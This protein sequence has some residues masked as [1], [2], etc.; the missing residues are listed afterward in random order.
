MGASSAHGAFPGANGQ[1]A[2]TRCEDGY[3]CA[4]ARIWT[5]NGDGS[6]A[7][8]LVDDPGHWD[9]DPSFSSDGR[10]IVFQRCVINGACGIAAVDV[11]GNGLHQLTTGGL[12]PGDD[13]PAFSPDG[14]KIVFE[15]WSPGPEIFQIWVMGAD[16]S[17]PHALTSGPAGNYAPVFSPDGKQ[18]VYG[19]YTNKSSQVWLMNADGSNPHQLTSPVGMFDSYPRFSPDGTHIAFTR[20]HGGQCPVWIMA[21]DGSG[22]HQVT[23]SSATDGRPDFSPDGTRLVFQRNMPDGTTS[24][25]TQAVSGGS[26]TRLTTTDDYSVSWGRVPT[27]SIDSA[28]TIAGAARAGHT[29]TATAGATS[30]GGSTS[31]QWL[32]CAASCSPIAGAT[33]GSYKATNAD[34]GAQLEVQQTQASA[35]GSVTALSAASAQVAAEPGAAIVKLVRRS[36]GRVLVRLLC[37]AEQSGVCQ[38]RVSLAVAGTGKHRVAFASGSFQLAAG[39]SGKV[40]LR[41]SKRGRALLAKGRKLRL[42]ATLT[43]TDDSGNGTT[44]KPKLTLPRR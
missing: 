14:Q 16:G 7:A 40:T 37:P 8:R 32:R 23:D 1:I 27:P 15:R 31:L 38:G 29:L 24:L 12:V 33:G 20:C 42:L 44:A 43:T 17:N 19:H 25:Y 6:G 26:A 18:I 9:A 28:P 5:A 34:V 41:A 35:G 10:S 21:S 39:T 4:V 2:F 36:H 11:N 22:A 30:W 13:Y 3:D